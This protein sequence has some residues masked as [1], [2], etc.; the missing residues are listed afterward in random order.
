MLAER[1]L[2]QTA[3]QLADF[4]LASSQHQETLAVVLEKY[5]T[6]MEDYRRLKSDY[7]EER[8]SRERYKQM[9]RGQERNPFVLV[10]VDGDGYIFDD[11]LVSSGAEGGQRA[12][13]LLNDAVMRSMRDR[14]LDQCRIM[15]RVYANLA[16]LS[17]ALARSNLAGKEKRSLAPFAANFTRSNDLFDFVDA[18]ELKENADFKIR[19]MFRQFAENAQCKHIYF[20]GCHDVGYINELTPYASNRD[21][22]TLVRTYAFH[23]E[24]TRLGMRIEDFPNIFRTTALSGEPVMQ[25]T[26]PAPSPL[27]AATK[28]PSAP[29]VDGV[30]KVC[31]FFQKGRCTYGNSCKNL[32]IKQ[33]ANG[34]PSA[35]ASKASDIKNWRDDTTNGKASLPFQLS[36]VARN[37]NSFMSGHVVATSNG[38]DTVQDNIGTDHDLPQAAEIP[39]GQ[40][41]VTK[42][43]HR[44][45]PSIPHCSAADHEAF[46][47]R[48]AIQKMCNNYHVGGYCAHGV[49][50]LYDH[51]PMS[52]GV[53][54]ALKHVVYGN[55]CPRKGACRRVTCL[56]GHVC[57]KAECTSR[58][59][60]AYCK[61]NPRVHELDMSVAEYVQGE[62]P[63]AAFT[64]ATAA[65]NG[66]A[67]ATAEAA[68]GSISDRDSQRPTQPSSDWQT[69]SDGETDAAEGALLDSEDDASPH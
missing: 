17:K 59:G 40:I 54:N 16:G 63:P 58:G 23:P 53:L 21:R 61:F 69:E 49:G 15:V 3:A 46:K 13:Q 10:L 52:P 11:D 9:A 12:A 14:G 6:L 26:A 36:N 30:T 60:K 29:S 7:E 31:Y 39:P 19:A 20:A 45:D 28:A 57:Q 68:E 1:E 67:A 8:D 64:S 51:R 18:G 32:H 43:G 50:C 55:P 42:D 24:F 25:K 5:G 2:E 37:D 41:P 56:Y 66:E 34:Q 62:G 65:Q 48:I 47:A 27:K 44:L 38:S 22:I 4:R 35:S 33:S